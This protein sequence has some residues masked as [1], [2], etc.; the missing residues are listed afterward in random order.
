M[1]ARNGHLKIIFTFLDGI[2]R[3]PHVEHIGDF[4]RIGGSIIN[5]YQERIHMANTDIE[6]AVT[7]RERSQ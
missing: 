2:I 5:R 7:L 3:M 6:W 4:Y 1:E